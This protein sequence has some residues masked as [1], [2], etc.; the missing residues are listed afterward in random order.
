[1]SFD[2]LTSPWT[3]IT[4]TS[5]LLTFRQLTYSSRPN[6]KNTPN[7]GMKT[8]AKSQFVSVWIRTADNVVQHFRL[9]R[10][11]ITLQIR[12]FSNRK[13]LVSLSLESQ[14]LDTV[15]LVYLLS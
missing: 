4:G 1:M 5:S 7:I 12:D 6:V 11:H 2:D 10:L 8:F 3:S 15:L 14:K 13:D 9:E